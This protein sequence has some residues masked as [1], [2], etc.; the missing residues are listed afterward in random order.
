MAIHNDLGKEGELLAAKWLAER[1]Y[2]LLYRNWKYKYHEI[3]IIALKNEI[4]HIVEVKAR[5]ASQ[6][7]FPE[8]SVTKKKFRFLKSAAHE[9]LFRHPG[10]KWL[11]Y[12][13][14]S[15]TIHKDGKKDF[16][17][18]EDVFL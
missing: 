10:Y 17:F 15:I 9:F 13:I 12:D 7:G 2:K 1:G 16:Y 18:L 3:D 4:L 8:D 11:Q 14:L 5:N 6:F